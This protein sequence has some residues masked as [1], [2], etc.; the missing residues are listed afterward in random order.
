MAARSVVQERDE[1]N[2]RLERLGELLADDRQQRGQLELGCQRL[3]DAVDG[4][5]LG[6]ALLGLVDEAAGPQ[7]NAEAGGQGREQRY[8]ALVEGVL[9]IEVLEGD[10]AQDL[11]PDEQR[12]E[13]RRQRGFSLDV[14]RL[15]QLAATL[16]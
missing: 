9:A 14:V 12:H 15:P 1:G 11:V 10:R 6:H 2:V 4:R 13:D 16:T 7:R 8:V 3:P 5:Q